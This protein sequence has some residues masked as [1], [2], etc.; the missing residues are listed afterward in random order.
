M[1]WRYGRRWRACHGH[2]CLPKCEWDRFRLVFWRCLPFCFP[3]FDGSQ[4]WFG[5]TKSG[6]WEK[7][8]NLQSLPWEF[9]K[10]GNICTKICTNRSFG[11]LVQKNTEKIRPEIQSGS[12]S[13]MWENE[14]KTA[15][16]KEKRRSYDLR[17][18]AN[19]R[20]II[21]CRLRKKRWK[22]TRSN[23]KSLC[24]WK[25]HSLLYRRYVLFQYFS[26]IRD[27]N[28]LQVGQII[29]C[30]GVENESTA[31]FCSKRDFPIVRQEA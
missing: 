2:P 24:P 1:E 31:F 30:L 18:L 4:F 23:E 11:H 25:F 19:M 8:S 6:S 22:K 21:R 28:T 17:F 5:E 12:A 29:S 27:I 9:C 7:A 15:E 16:N 13:K 3:P 26:H 14:R 10:I 20:K